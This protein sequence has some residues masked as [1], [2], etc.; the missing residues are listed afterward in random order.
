MIFVQLLGT[1][2]VVLALADVFLTVL[3]ARSGVLTLSSLLNRFIWS[4]FRL[5]SHWFPRRE[6]FVLSLCGPVLMVVTTTAWILLLAVGFALIYWPAVGSAIQAS[7]GLTPTDFSV[8]LYFSGFS[9]AT[10]GTGDFVAE[11]ATY[12]ILMVVEAAIGF[13]IITL[14]TTYFLSVFNALLRRN[15]LAELLHFQTAATGDAA[16]TL[17]RLANG[18]SLSNG[19]ASLLAV[20][21]GVLRLQESHHAYPVLHYFRLPAPYYALARVMLL[22]LDLATL[23]KTLSN[24]EGDR[25]LS[26]S[27]EVAVLWHGGMH[28]LED[29]SKNFL[30]RQYR[31]E[32]S[33]ASPAEVDRWRRRYHEV[34]QRL[35]QAGYDVRPD[36]RIGTEE[37]V[38]LRQCWNHLLRAFAE[39]MQYAWLEI[40][41]ATCEP[42]TWRRNTAG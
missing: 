8:A 27:V 39:Y 17:S 16:E 37:Y 18:S 15:T 20:A 32:K 26:H 36:L 22:A 2:C 41:A 42:P 5:L 29:L 30:P 4:G 19:G 9:L 10:L 7:R 34:A 40:D 14:S 23:I 25:S 13:G 1:V 3:Y 35:K 12:R 11:N 21:N 28:A 6:A 33:S 38:Q 31:S 24:Q